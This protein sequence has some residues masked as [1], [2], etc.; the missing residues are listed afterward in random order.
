MTVSP[1]PPVIPSFPAGPGQMLTVLGSKRMT[2]YPGSKS[3]GGLGDRSLSLASLG[4][5]AWP[6]QLRCPLEQLSRKLIV[7]HQHKVKAHDSKK[8][9]SWEQRLKRK[10][11]GPAPSPPSF[12]KM[13]HSSP[14]IFLV[15]L[16]CPWRRRGSHSSA[17]HLNDPFH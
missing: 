17:I 14:D 9:K 13:I 1:L 7:A 10:C 15:H 3:A 12:H 2:A 11:Q 6:E 8:G 4:V 16:L 5:Q